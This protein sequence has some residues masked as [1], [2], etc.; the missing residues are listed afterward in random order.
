MVF[1]CVAFA[2]GRLHQTGEGGKDVDGGVDALIVELAV[3]ENLAFG[4]VACQ[5]RDGVGD[6]WK[7]KLLA[8]WAQGLAD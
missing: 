2:D 6:V 5:V 7:G 4:N 3:D 8:R 1:A